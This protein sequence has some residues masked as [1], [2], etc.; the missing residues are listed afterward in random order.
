MLGKLIKH[1]F[2][3]TAPTMLGLFAV[4]MIS[5][6]GARFSLNVL[7]H[8]GTAFTDVL[9]VIL[10]IIFF[11]AGFASGFACVALMITRFAKNLL[12]DE[13]YVMMTLPVTPAQHIWSKL[14]VSTVWFFG[15]AIFGMLSMMIAFA[16]TVNYKYI[17]D[18]IGAVFQYI[19][20]AGVLNGILSFILGIIVIAAFIFISCLLFYASI[21]TGYSFDKHKKLLS[22]VFFFAYQMLINCILV[23][24]GDIISRLG[25]DYWLANLL[26][27]YEEFSL[28]A[29][30]AGFLVMLVCE[31]FYGAIYYCITHYFL[32]RKL[33]LE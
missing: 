32:K 6:L 28:A 10:E 23:L 18:R 13:G 19:G 25:I 11:V 33:N 29:L 4:L 31:V 30:N 1:E 9:A 26:P 22:V 5:S 16:N 14:I 15:S 12:G 24:L 21:A 20:T 7:S 2:R 27:T 8:G 3:A 17:F